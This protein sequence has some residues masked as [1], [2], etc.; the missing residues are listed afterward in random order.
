MD[1]WSLSGKVLL[2][3]GGARGIG[4]ATA[5]E[6]ARRGALPVLADLD[7]D[8]LAA[9]A[10]GISP[11]PVTIGRAIPV[12]SST[13]SCTVTPSTRSRHATWPPTSVRIE[14]V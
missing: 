11:E 12:T 2:I 1:G 6:L 3:T 9:T 14:K 13:S 7:T 4:A 10:A 8:A 5:R